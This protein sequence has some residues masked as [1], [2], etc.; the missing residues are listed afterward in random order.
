MRGISTVVLALLLWLG[1]VTLAQE[2]VNVLFIAVDDLRPE[3]GCYGSEMALTPHIDGLASGGMVFKRAYC[4][5]PVCGASRASMLASLYPIPGERFLRY[6]TRLDQDAPGA[7]TLP[8]VFKEAGYTTISNGK[9]FH[10]LE[11][12]AGRSWSEPPWRRRGGGALLPETMAERSARGRGS[13]VEAPDVA[14][15][16]YI[17][18]QCATKT[19]EDLRRLKE[20]DKPF[21]LACGFIRPHLPFYAPKKYWDLY[22]ADTLLLA[23]NRFRPREAPRALRGS[24]EYRSYFLGELRPGTDRFH[25]TMRHGYLASV[26]YIDAQ[27]GRMLQTLDKLGLADNTIV[28][29]WGDHGFHL[30]E[31]DFWGKH[32]TL[33]HAARVPLIIRLPRSINPPDAATGGQAVGIVESVDIFPTLIELCRLE[34]PRDIQGLSFSRLFWQP[35]TDFRDNAYVRYGNADTLFTKDYAYTRFGPADDQQMLFDLKA[36]PQENQN[37]ANAPGSARQLALL[38]YILWVRMQEAAGKP[39]FDEDGESLFPG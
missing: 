20:Q 8:Q 18:G 7:V 25:R 1:P 3:L 10:D 15:D 13:I 22:D 39:L 29:F 34:H 26:S 30:G 5:I 2:K 23:E 36:D 19:I 14:D 27:V 37:V 33:E 35:E 32:N 17:D 28:V 16:A 31:H 6:D 4:N 11:D 38:R 24:S 21:F 12:A 9:V